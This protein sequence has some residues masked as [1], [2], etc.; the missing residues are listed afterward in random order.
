MSTAAKD[1][2][3]A[4]SRVPSLSFETLKKLSFTHS[5]VYILLLVVWLVPGLAVYESIFGFIHGV[6]WILMVLLILLALRA[7]VVPLRTG[8]AVGVLGGLAPFFGSWEFIREGRHREGA[9]T[10]SAGG[11]SE[12]G[13]AERS[14]GPNAR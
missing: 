5:G 8:V 7:R 4:K 3:A 2:V 9:E 10:A 14:V 6:G 13:V 12:A 1:E 11:D